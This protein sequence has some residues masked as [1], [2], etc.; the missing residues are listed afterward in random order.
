MASVGPQKDASFKEEY[1]GVTMFTMLKLLS[2]KG[3]KD[4]K[5]ECFIL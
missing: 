2:S 1:K 5:V 3:E 4:R